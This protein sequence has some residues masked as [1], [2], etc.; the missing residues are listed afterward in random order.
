MTEG[1]TGGKHVGYSAGFK[2]QMVKR[3][4]D[5][6]G[7]SPKRLADETGVSATQLYVWL[8]AT[9]KVGLMTQKKAPST[10]KADD[11]KTRSAE[12]KL[13]LLGEAVG[14][15][16]EELGAFL[17]REG[18]HEDELQSW[19]DVAAGALSG[20]K[21]APSGPLTLSQRRRLASAEKEAKELRRELRRKEKAL[22]E[23]AALLVLEKKLV[24][25]GWDERRTQ[26][27]DEDD[28]AD[29]KKEP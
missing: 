22:A 14:L 25:L 2:A 29:E 26:G 15:K 5:P 1:A 18:L 7:V 27:D 3:M 11:G 17:R 21:A 20:A 9:R 10:L 12:E 19:R 8:N 13:R 24:A 16:G 6:P 28:E 23:A 4:V